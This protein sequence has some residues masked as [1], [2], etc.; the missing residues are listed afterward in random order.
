MGV[1]LL[2]DDTLVVYQQGYR[3]PM[4][5]ALE[6][7]RCNAKAELPKPGPMFA[8]RQPTY[9]RLRPALAVHPVP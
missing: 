5:P 8:T 6:F 1:I 2:C 3:V 7:P 9:T 4:S